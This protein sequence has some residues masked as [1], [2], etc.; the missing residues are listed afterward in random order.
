M[1]VPTK[2][3]VSQ[4]KRSYAP[5]SKIFASTPAKRPSPVKVMRAQVAPHPRTLSNGQPRPKKRTW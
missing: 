1:A 4:M 5:T 2:K 3:P